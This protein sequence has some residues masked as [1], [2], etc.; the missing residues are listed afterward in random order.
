VA[1]FCVI[2]P[3]STD[4]SDFPVRLTDKPQEGLCISHVI[5]G[6]VSADN[7]MRISVYRQVQFTPDAALFLTV[8][9]SPSTHPSPKMV[10]PLIG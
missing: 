7:L 10:M 6:E 9:F 5:Q 8:F 3:I 1:P 2:S 4:G